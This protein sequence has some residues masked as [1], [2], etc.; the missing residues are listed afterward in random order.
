MKYVDLIKT[1]YFCILLNRDK[2]L[3][4][5]YNIFV[6]FHNTKDNEI[7]QFINLDL[8]GL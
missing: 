8:R 5:F 6:Y 3:N 7:I 1:F 2:I 4:F